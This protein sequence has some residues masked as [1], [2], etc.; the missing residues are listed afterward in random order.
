MESGGF[1]SNKTFYVFP[2]HQKMMT[3]I[4]KKSIKCPSPWTVLLA[5]KGLHVCCIVVTVPIIFLTV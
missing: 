3:R 1:T 2:V 5:E 4:F